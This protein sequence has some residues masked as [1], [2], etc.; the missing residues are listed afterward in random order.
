MIVGFGKF[1]HER[2]LVNARG[3]DK[4]PLDGMVLEEL[5]TLM[6]TRHQELPLGLLCK[7]LARAEKA[8]ADIQADDP[9]RALLFDIHRGAL[10]EIQSRSRGL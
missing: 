1:A 9:S 2:R 10:W 8:M 5:R 6:T 4:P 3:F 7:M